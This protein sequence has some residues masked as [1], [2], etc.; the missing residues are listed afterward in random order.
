MLYSLPNL[1]YKYDA[2]EPYIDALT[3]EIHHDKHHG[4]YVQ[5]LNDALSKFPEWSDRKIEEILSN[6]GKL[7]LEIRD[8]V[9]NNG[10][11]H[12][13]HSL[14]WTILSPKGGGGPKEPLAGKLKDV[15][16]SID[17]FREIFTNVALNRFGSGWAWLSLDRSGKLVVHS[18]PNQDTPFI[19][20]YIP[21][22][23]LDVWE[24]AYYLKYQNKRGDYIKAF[25][26]VIDWERINE[27]LKEK[28]RS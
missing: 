26:S 25:W 3:M 28:E 4:T 12:Y 6:P 18:T 22:F 21:I 27:L 14:F 2:L 7:P 13:N 1:S 11:G 16:G 9:R 23:G 5:K 19:D 10:G 17:G 20:S 15:F 24:H 8:A